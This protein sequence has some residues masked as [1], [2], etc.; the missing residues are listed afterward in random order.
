MTTH[1]SRPWRSDCGCCNP[2]QGKERLSHPCQ[3]CWSNFDCYWEKEWTWMENSWTRNP[4]YLKLSAKCCS[5][6]LLPS[7]R[8]YFFVG[9]WLCNAVFILVLPSRS[10]SFTALPLHEAK[11]LPSHLADFRIKKNKLWLVPTSCDRVRKQF[12][13]MFLIDCMLD[14]GRGLAGRCKSSIFQSGWTCGWTAQQI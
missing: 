14:V 9:M 6:T 8:S 13:Q 5:H 10:S 7:L 12:C 11:S 3:P 2:A 4:N 1:L